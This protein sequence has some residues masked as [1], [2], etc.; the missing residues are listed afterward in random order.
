M[1]HV[2]GNVVHTQMTEAKNLQIFSGPFK[3]NWRAMPF[4]RDEAMPLAT[5]WGLCFVFLSVL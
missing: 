2:I 5:E 4:R 3:T 1:K